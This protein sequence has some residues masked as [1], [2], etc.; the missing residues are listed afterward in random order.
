MKNSIKLS[1]LFFLVSTGLFAATPVKT[2]IGVVP[3]KKNMITFSSLP[4][5]R[6][7]DIKVD[8]IN[9]GK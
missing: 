4:S 7:I 3:A 8:K 9:L 2:Y 6:D 1:A 5:D